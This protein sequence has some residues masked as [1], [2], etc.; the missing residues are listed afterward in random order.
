MGRRLGPETKVRITGEMDRKTFGS[1]EIDVKQIEVLAAG[2]APAGPSGASGGARRLGVTVG[3]PKWSRICRMTA[4]R[5]MT[6]M[7]FIVPPHR[8][9]TSGST[10]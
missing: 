2:S 1:N 6:E 3:S 9:Q 10:S 8:G 7:I 5:S 4:G